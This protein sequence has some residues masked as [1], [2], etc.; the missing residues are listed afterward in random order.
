VKLLLI[1]SLLLHL[2][3]DSPIIMQFGSSIISKSG[4]PFYCGLE[5]G[6]LGFIMEMYF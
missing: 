5:L 1:T 4:P 3:E 6:G 2:D